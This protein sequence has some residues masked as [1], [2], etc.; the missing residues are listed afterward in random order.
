MQ[1]RD[2]SLHGQRLATQDK[3][4]FI[5]LNQCEQFEFILF[6]NTDIT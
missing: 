2:E 4:F 1:L 5:S 6:S 3:H